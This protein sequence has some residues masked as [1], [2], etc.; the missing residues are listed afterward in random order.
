MDIIDKQTQ[1]YLRELSWDCSDSELD[2]EI[3]EVK[4]LFETSL[5]IQNA[6]ER[7]RCVLNAYDLFIPI[8]E[9]FRKEKFCDIIDDED[10]LEEFKPNKKRRVN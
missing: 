2:E 3:Y 6:T 8:I 5:N 7:L 10:F 9:D 1:Y 4:L